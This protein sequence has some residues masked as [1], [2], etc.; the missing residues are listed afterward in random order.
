MNGSIGYGLVLGGLAFATFGALVGLVTGLRRSEAGFPWVMRAVWGF[1]GCMVAANL[2]MVFA[3]VTHD[4]SVKYVAQVG[5]RDTPLLYTVVSLWSA[6]EGSILFWG[7]IMGLYIAAFAWMHRREHARYMQL[8]LGTMLAVGVF[9]AFLIAGPAN[10]WGAVSPVPADGPGPN[11]LLQNHIL[12]VIHPPFLYLGYV[13][14]TVPFGV[15]VAGLL[16]GE[17]GEAWMAPLRRWTLV[18][19]LFLSIGIILGAWWAYAV[20]G[21]GGYW[22]WDPVENASFLP[23]LTATAFMH[24]T[25][26]QERKR[27]L[28]LWTL[29]LALA[30]FVLTI[31]GTFMTRSGIF[32]SVHSFTQSDIGPTFLVFLGVLLVVCVGLLAVRGP[33]LVPEGRLSSL[34]SREA[35]ILMNN[36]VFVAITFTVLLGTLYPLVSEAV[37]GVR[38]SVGEPYF[39]KMAVPGGIAVLFLMGVGPVLPWGT[40]DKATLRRQFLIPAAVGLIVT[41]ICFA[42]GLRGVY[43]LLTFGLAGFVTVVTLRELVSPI[44]VRMTERKEG[45][46]T[47]VLTSATKAQRRFGGYVVHLGIVILIVAVSASSSY[48]KHTSGTLKK[49]QT[50]ML[51]G[52]QLKYLGL[53]SG[54]EPHRTFVAAR[55]EVTTPG[56]KVEE[57]KP[58]LNY[59]E[60]ST[61]PIGTPAV[62]ETAGEDL[63]ISLMAFSEQAGNASF[64]VWVFPL[65]GWI[66]WCIP[67]FVLGTIIALWP[68]RRAAVAMASSEAGASPLPGGD[69]ERGAA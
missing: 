13:G 15:A 27:M 68:R 9:F 12:M 48:V 34:A 3:L 14:M 66:W 35:S 19:W 50:M 38:V 37:R 45:L 23:W 21:W 67:L 58:R 42:V 20:L 47:A 57:M 64:N 16:R 7:L 43:P 56:G 44:R 18:A 69:A 8:A 33:L 40:P 55:V 28:K 30:S 41:A 29:S 17:I 49:D 10:P 24:S 53:V 36:L 46:V 52:Y 54:E 6:L 32:N 62:R 65:V 59:Y 60:R 51:D 1:A 25:M 11:P 4:F 31:L 39:N 63:Y 22:A 5:S 61:D 2:M 26:V